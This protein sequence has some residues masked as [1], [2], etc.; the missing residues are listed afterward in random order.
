MG[1]TTVILSVNPAPVTASVA[2]AFLVTQQ[3]MLLPS[4]A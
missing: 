3:G 2:L 4:S 1:E